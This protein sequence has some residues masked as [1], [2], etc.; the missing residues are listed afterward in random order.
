MDTEAQRRTEALLDLLELRV[1]L[2][3]ALK[4]LATFGFAYDVD[5]CL[6]ELRHVRG[7]VAA[8]VDGRLSA[9]DCRDWADALEIREDVGFGEHGEELMKEFVFR[10]ANPEINGPFIAEEW[11]ARLAEFAR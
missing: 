9:D 4:E 8:F 11:S 10:V 7:V 6:I 1:P 3:Q 5:L 2:A